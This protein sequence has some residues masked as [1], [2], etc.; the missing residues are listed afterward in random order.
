[1]VLLRMIITYIGQKLAT[2]IASLSNTFRLLLFAIS[3]AIAD[4]SS[5]VLQYSVSNL[6]SLK[7]LSKTERN[8][9]FHHLLEHWTSWMRIFPILR[10]FEW[11]T[12]KFLR[13][14]TWNCRNY[15]NRTWT[16]F[17][18]VKQKWSVIPWNAKNWFRAGTS[19]MTD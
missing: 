12:S 14:F 17:R 13:H 1:M 3:E 16:R 5:V 10:D 7:K 15:V 9:M 2:L 19:K 8:F 11:K 4:Y 18:N 6:N